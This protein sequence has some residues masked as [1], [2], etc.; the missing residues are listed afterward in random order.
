[1]SHDER[2]VRAMSDDHLRDRIIEAGA[3]IANND[4]RLSADSSADLD[5]ALDQFDAALAEYGRRRVAAWR[6]GIGAIS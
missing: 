4:G 1:M 6:I 3:K 2:E 5:L